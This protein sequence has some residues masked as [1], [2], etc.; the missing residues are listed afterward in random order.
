MATSTCGL[1]RT[2]VLRSREFRSGEPRKRRP[3]SDKRCRRRRRMMV[4]ISM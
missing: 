3:V 2:S 1:Y 4:K